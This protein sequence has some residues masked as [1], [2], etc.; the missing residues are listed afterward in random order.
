MFKNKATEWQTMLYSRKR[1]AF[2]TLLRVFL[3]LLIYLFIFLRNR[4]PKIQQDCVQ[5]AAPTI[6]FVNMW[7]VSE[8]D[9]F[10][11]YMLHC[12]INSE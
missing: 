6:V 9:V 10:V 2:S 3:L 11:T 8:S 1:D 12:L 7:R 4:D 5:A